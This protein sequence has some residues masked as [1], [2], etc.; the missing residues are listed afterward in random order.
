M[1]IFSWYFLIFTLKIDSSIYGY[2]FRDQSSS[3]PQNQL[4]L[5]PQLVEQP[6]P[7]ILTF[8]I[9]HTKMPLKF[10]TVATHQVKYMYVD[11]FFEY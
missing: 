4:V 3:G 7:V 9:E 8:D 6:E 5:K 10:H 11:F 1:L 2:D